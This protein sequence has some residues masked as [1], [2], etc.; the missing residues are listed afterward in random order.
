[1]AILVPKP[2]PYWHVDAKWICGIILLFVLG[3]SL[4]LGALVKLTD[5]QRGPK[6]AALAI[7]AAF[8]R[9]D[10]ATAKEEAGREIAKQGGAIYPLADFPE[11]VIT[12]KDLDLPAKDI[13]LKVFGPIASSIYNDGIEGTADRF[14]KTPEQKE[15]FIKDAFFFKPF[16]KQTHQSLKSIAKLFTLLSVFFALALIYFSAGWGRLANPGLLLL[17]VSL[18]GSFLALALTHPPKS[19]DGPGGGLPADLTSEIG[20]PLSQT[21][22]RITILALALLVAALIGKI[23]SSIIGHKQSKA[24]AVKAA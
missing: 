20:Q 2:R 17:L 22:S 9:G 18:P 19:G 3:I 23:V 7:G 24:K 14:A 4:I 13:K 11:V 1:M 16:T 8:V 6:I 21:Y 12:E 5:E 10:E 15:K